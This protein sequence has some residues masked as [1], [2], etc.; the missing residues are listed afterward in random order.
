MPLSAALLQRLKAKG[1][2]SVVAEK[3]EAWECPNIWNKYH[4][5]NE[6]C[7]ANWKAKHQK[8]LVIEDIYDKIPSCWRLVPDEETGNCYFWNIN[9]NVVQWRCPVL[10]DKENAKLGPIPVGLPLKTPAITA[11]Q[12]PSNFQMPPNF[13]MPTVGEIKMPSA[14]PA[15][16]DSRDGGG[17]KRY[18]P[19][20]KEDKEEVDPMDPSSYSDAP[21][22]DWG[23]GL[24]K[25]GDAKTGV[26]VT[27]NGPLFQQRPY[28]APGAIMRMNQAAKAEE[29][30]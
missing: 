30:E 10:L 14:P 15:R 2:K 4:T 6:W 12:M 16:K 13:Q 28:P 11:V 3:E 26:D 8:S 5:C 7:K 24:P 27:A 20:K 29:D 25:Q 22:G 18:Q 19:P 21:K 9:T 17:R 23:R 1:I